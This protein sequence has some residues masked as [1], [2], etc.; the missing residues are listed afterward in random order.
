MAER[1]EPHAT[2]IGPITLFTE[3]APPL[4]SIQVQAQ[5]VADFFLAIEIHGGYRGEKLNAFLEPLRQLR[6]G[7]IDAVYKQYSSHEVEIAKSKPEFKEGREAHIIY[8]EYSIEFRQLPVEKQLEKHFLNARAQMWGMENSI[9]VLWSEWNNYRK[10]VKVSQKRMLPKLLIEPKNK[11]R[12]AGL[13]G[14]LLSWTAVN[15]PERTSIEISSLAST[16]LKEMFLS[17]RIALPAHHHLPVQLPERIPLWAWQ[18]G[19]RTMIPYWWELKESSESGREQ[20]DEATD[21]PAHLR[22]MLSAPPYALI[23]RA[24][25]DGR[26]WKYNPLEEVFPYFEDGRTAGIRLTYETLNFRGQDVQVAAKAAVEQVNRLDDRT[27]DVWRV[28]LWKAAEKGVGNT[29]VYTR[30]HIDTREVA[31]LLGY[32]KHHKG[33]MKPEHLLEVHN[34]LEHLERMKIYLTPDVKGTLEQDAGQT[35]GKRKSKQ[36]VKAREEKVISVMAREID[37]N[38]LG[39]ECHMV[40]ELALGDWARFFPRS[41]SPMFKALVEL[42]NRSG[43]HR[44]AKRIGTELVLLYR[45]DARGP[46]VKRLKWSTILDRAGLMREIE[47]LRRSPN[48]SRITKYAEGAMDALKEIGVV[49]DWRIDPDALARINDG[50][51]KPG[52]FE[53]WLDAMVE[54]TAPQEV[55]GILDTITAP[56]KK[57]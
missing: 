15:L 29:N 42:P 35:K 6:A 32:K 50:L 26:N 53:T 10:S 47:E 16:L 45:Q 36:L 51:G 54:I 37:R 18:D 13:H 33:G 40:W 48:R 49:Q 56:K 11:R 38:L 17:D 8:D 34:A 1:Q 55:L 12:S 4:P 21:Y 2:R 7:N 28:I 5:V 41:Y 43:V 30:I 39:Q 31:Q 20:H 9:P 52:N 24:S 44:W 46:A 19:L 14:S 3:A 25:R 22:R 27:A 57:A 23:D